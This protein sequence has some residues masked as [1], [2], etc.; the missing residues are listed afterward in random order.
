MAPDRI[1]VLDHGYLQLVETWGSDAR[2]IEAA[3][4]S[5]N[6]GFLGWGPRCKSC[7]SP[8]STDGPEP[9]CPRCSNV[10]EVV[11]GDEKLL[12]Y[13]WKNKHYTPF[14]MAGM[15]IEVSAPI[16]VYRQWHRHRTQSYNEESAR[17][18]ALPDVNYIPSVER[19][20]MGG[21]A[22]KQAGTASGAEVL[23]ERKAELFRVALDQQYRAQEELYQAALASGVPK[24]IARVHIG[25]G[26][27]SR[28]RVCANLRN[29]LAF[30]SLR[31][32]AHAQW[33]V[34]QYGLAWGTLLEQAF[35][36]TWAL[37]QSG[38]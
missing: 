27:Y 26:R 33:E 20:M 14:E 4:M 6:K 5:T 18:V 10:V 17:Y 13:L 21:G 22:N 11:A 8:V 32:D 38:R 2:I 23:D 16:F 12:A 30:E 35:P 1:E 31:L 15:V 37:F 25:V 3:R 28:M 24:E 7:E 19:L 36:R 29:I 9:W 34:R